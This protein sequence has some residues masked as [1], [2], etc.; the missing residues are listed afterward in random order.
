MAKVETSQELFEARC[1]KHIAAFYENNEGVNKMMKLD[2]VECSAQEM[3]LVMSHVPN[4]GEANPLGTIH[5]GITAWLLDTAMGMVNYC[6]IGEGATPTVSMS[7]NYIEGI[8][9]G[10]E[11]LLTSWIDRIGGNIVDCRAE[12]RVNGRIK[13]SAIGTSYRLHLPKLED[14]LF[15]GTDDVKL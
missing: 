15:S 6:Y 12:A 13:A 3:K 5:G 11:V 9:E 14:E 10:D 2:F 7:I 1:R 4:H 8:K